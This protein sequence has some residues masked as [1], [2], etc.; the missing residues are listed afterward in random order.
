MKTAPKGRWLYIVPKDQ[1]FFHPPRFPT[2]SKINSPSALQQMQCTA[3]ALGSFSRYARA[4][5]RALRKSA[6]KTCLVPI[7]TRSAMSNR[8]NGN[9][10]LTLGL[11]LR[12]NCAVVVAR[13]NS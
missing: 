2:R 6:G 4:L 9:H 1:S 10:R 5:L 11:R 13:R 7:A 12:E 3:R 8:A